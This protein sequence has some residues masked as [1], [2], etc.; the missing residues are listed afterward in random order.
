[1]FIASASTVSFHILHS[2]CRNVV[3]LAIGILVTLSASGQ[4]HAQGNVVKRTSDVI[5]GRKA[6]M[7]LTMD[8]FQPAQKNGDG[9][10]FLVSGG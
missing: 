2:L 9:V 6:G 5:Y 8:V 3:L 4:A 7:A 1:M 10:I